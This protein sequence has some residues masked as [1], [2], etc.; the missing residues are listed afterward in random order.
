MMKESDRKKCMREQ[1]IN[2]I[3]SLPKDIIMKIKEKH[4]IHNKKKKLMKHLSDKE[5]L[6]N[7]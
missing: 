4:F 1:E 6:K 5:S 3:K 2:N 7:Q